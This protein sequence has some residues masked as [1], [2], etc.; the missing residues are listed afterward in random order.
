MMF[1]IVIQRMSKSLKKITHN[2]KARAIIDGQTP[3]EFFM[4]AFGDKGR[5]NRFSYLLRWIDKEAHSMTG[6]VSRPFHHYVHQKSTR[7]NIQTDWPDY[8]PMDKIVAELQ[9]DMED[10]IVELNWGIY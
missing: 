3:K 1:G 10:H 8:P 9:E 7:L 5:T 4:Q 6:D 2:M